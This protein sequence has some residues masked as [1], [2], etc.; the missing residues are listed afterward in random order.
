MSTAAPNHQLQNME[1]VSRLCHA[2]ESDIEN[3][4]DSVTERVIAEIPTFARYPFAEQQELRRKL[5]KIIVSA[6]AVGAGP[7]EEE[8]QV[9]RTIVRRRVFFGLPVGDVLATLQIFSLE[10]S[11]RLREES[12]G[13]KDAE[14]IAEL[15]GVH[16]VWVQAM[17]GAVTEAYAEE[18]SLRKGREVGLRQR[19][20]E[21]LRGGGAMLEQ[22]SEAARDLGFD[23]GGTFQA[24]S[25]SSEA[26]PPEQLTHLQSSL[27]CVQGV[28]H[29]GQRDQIV[30]V[31]AQSIDPEVVGAR[32]TRQLGD[33]AAFGVGLS[34]PTL[35]G[36]EL[37]IS[38]AT[39]ALSLARVGVSGAVTF[40]DHWLE[41]S[42]AGSCDRIEP[43]LSVGRTAAKEHPH[44]ADAVRAFAR[45]GFSISRAAEE[46]FV[47]PNTAAYRLGRWQELTGWDPRSLQGFLLSVVALDLPAVETL[48]VSKGQSRV[49]P[50]S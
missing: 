20:L 9:V 31:L 7:T 21:A 23:P 46:L 33:S 22:A 34:R 40:A 6:L 3:F 24:Y 25:V 50:G 12:K 47:H 35:L 41:A 36:A 15:L 13:P 10:L 27:S 45:S 39:R 32:I 29:C 2:V 42:L 8:M 14:A 19:L 5:I 1:S 26:C 43:L 30:V 44:I 4:S 49:D 48:A 18:V 16:W 28:V 37:S 11:K 38:D 17:S